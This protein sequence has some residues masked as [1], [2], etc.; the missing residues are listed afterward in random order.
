LEHHLLQEGEAIAGSNR[1]IS[2][3]NEDLRQEVMTA[4]RL[5][6]TT[7]ELQVSL[8]EV[9]AARDHYRQELNEGPGL[10]AALRQ[11]LETMRI[12]LQDSEEGQMRIANENNQHRAESDGYAA[13][14][15]GTRQ[16]LDSSERSASILDRTSK[17]QAGEIAAMGMAEN[18]CKVE[19]RDTRE[20]YDSDVS[21]AHEQTAAVIGTY[22]QLSKRYVKLK[23]AYQEWEVWES[24]DGNS[25][26][27]PPSVASYD[28]RGI[29]DSASAVKGEH[30][31]HVHTLLVLSMPQ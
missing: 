17:I 30:L 26:A 27:T 31:L 2:E 25:F 4:R 21:A 22:Q 15:R 6:Q 16:L 3:R 1:I 29:G 7:E 18:R 14:L 11:Q 10:D 23:D 13:H 12:R 28:A 20:A 8:R 9:I 19:L 5:R 24:D